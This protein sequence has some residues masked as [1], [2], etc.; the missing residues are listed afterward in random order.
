MGIH[1]DEM[2]ATASNS[3]EMN[4]LVQ[5]LQKVLDLVDMGNIKWFLGMEVI[6]N[7]EA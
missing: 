5:D 2:A 6:R 3:A 1:I 4:T 7:C